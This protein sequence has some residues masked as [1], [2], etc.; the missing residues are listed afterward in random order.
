MIRTL[1]LLATPELFRLACS[2]W[3][4]RVRDVWQESRWAQ[5]FTQEYLQTEVTANGEHRYR[6]TWSMTL[7][8]PAKGHPP[9]QQC[10]EGANAKLKRDVKGAAGTLCTHAAVVESLKTASVLWRSPLQPRAGLKPLTLM[11]ADSELATAFPRRPDAWMLGKHGVRLRM[12]F[13]KLCLFAP[14]PAL[15][16]RFRMKRTPYLQEDRTGSTRW[17]CCAVSKPESVPA[18]MLSQIRSLLRE[19]SCEVLS[20]KLQTLGIVTAQEAGHYF[21]RE[22]CDALFNRFC[23]QWVLDS[24]PAGEMMLCSC[25]AHRWHGH[26][27]HVY[28]VAEHWGLRSVVG[29]RIAHVQEAAREAREDRRGSDEEANAR[30]GRKR[31]RQG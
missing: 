28:A 9:T 30:P 2:L 1:A 11:A 4:Q 31:R 18:C 7:G 20:Q 13:G 8:G 12:P 23:L 29:Q 15:L 10:A 17:A 6:A 21:D 19:R 3:L 24:D 25:W 14:I 22:K 26:C 16:K 5:Y 27:V